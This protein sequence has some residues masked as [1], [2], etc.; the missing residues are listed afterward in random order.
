MGTLIKIF[1]IS[2]LRKRILLT[3]SLLAV[4]RIGV[5]VTLPGVDRGAMSKYMASQQ[6][7]FLGLFNMFSGGAIEQLSV[8]ALGIMPYISASIIFQ[9]LT[10]VIPTLD[11]LNKEGDQ[12]RKK[13]NQWTRYATM[14][15]A[16]VQG[17]FIAFYLENLSASSGAGQIV[18]DPGSFMFRVMTVLTLATGTAFIMWLGEQI[19]ERGIGNGMSLIIM[20]GIIAGLP[21]ALV[22][23]KQMVAS[24]QMSIFGLLSL[25][26]IVFG[27]I[28]AIVFMERGQRRIPVQYAKRLVGNRVGAAQSTHL[29]LRV[30]MAGVIPPIFASSI[31]MFPATI[32]SWTDAEWMQSIHNAFI[33][34]DW[35]YMV[36][37]TALILFFC[38]FYTAV[39][40]NPVDVAENLKKHG[41][42]IPG[43]RP[44]TKTAEYID[45]VLTRLTFG[46]AIYVAAVCVLPMIIQDEF[47][48]SFY[49]GGTSLLIIV[50]VALDT[51]Q[52][53]ESYFITTEYKD[54]DNNQGPR[55]RN[56]RGAPA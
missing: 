14:A 17:L 51:V 42:Y 19:T 47:H 56:R 29:P 8:F 3:L 53:I 16:M 40:F 23:T 33:P 36:F 45:Y 24:Q 9:L 43:I 50:S 31:L 44:G 52:Q 5:F 4:Y 38:F 18:H 13:I 2:E 48:V 1:Q 20:A 46:G 6:G 22:Q 37:Y 15:L 7:G 34:G 28:A 12:G 39:M 10:V 49:F 35:R 54:F 21:D 30:N 41:G 26:G 27:V 55:I 32:A 25:A 11:R